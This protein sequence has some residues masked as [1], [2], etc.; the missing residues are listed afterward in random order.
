MS[1]TD[2]SAARIPAPRLLGL[3]SMATTVQ[4]DASFEELLEFVRTVRGFDFTDYKRSSLKRRTTKRMHE[5]GIEDCP[6]YLRRLQD[7]P[8]EFAAL[9]NTILINVTSF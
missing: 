3:R 8:D 1:P 6:A 5:V 4:E 9:F 2:R 7:D